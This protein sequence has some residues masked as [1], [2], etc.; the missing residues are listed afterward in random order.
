MISTPHRQTV[1]LLADLNGQWID[2]FHDRN[3]LKYIVL[4]M[5]RSVSPTHGDQEGA[6]GTELRAAKLHPDTRVEIDPI[7]PLQARTLRVIHETRP[8]QPLTP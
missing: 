1:T 8:S 3:G 5:D 6:A 7:C 4:D 2:R